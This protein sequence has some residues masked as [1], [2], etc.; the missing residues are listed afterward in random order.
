MTPADLA[1]MAAI[2][3][4]SQ[5]SNEIAITAAA[6][7]I[8][9]VDGRGERS[10]AADGKNAKIMVGDAEVNTKTKWD[11]AALK[12]EFETQSTDPSAS[13]KLTQT[14]EVNGDGRLVLTAKIESRRLRT[15]EQKA[16][17]DKKP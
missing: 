9:F 7:K 3:Q 6:D 13:A 17:F 1:A 12:Q 15:P 10:Y 2:R 5:L 4:L 11:K 16:V 14:W 8:T